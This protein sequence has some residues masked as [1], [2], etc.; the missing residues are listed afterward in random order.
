MYGIPFGPSS[1][2]RNVISMNKYV[3]NA[4]TTK[5]YIE[6][7]V[8]QNASGSVNITGWTLASEASG[9][10]E[11]IPVGTRVP[12][13][14]VVNLTQNILL[15]P[16]DRAIISSGPSPIGLSFRENKCTGYFNDFQKFSPPLPQNCPT[17]SHELSSFYGTRYIHDPVCIDYANTVPRCRVPAEGKTDLS[18]TCENFLTNYLNYNGCVN[19]HSGDAD[20]N[21]TTWRIYLGRRAATGKTKPMWRTDHEI[22]KLFDDRYKTVDSFSY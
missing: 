6:I 22:V 5:E 11:V 13:F 17:A 8:A 3:S 14:G 16:G 15:D 1:Q 21:G 19:A 20:F 18:V 7:S 9:N 2:Y 10:T 12:T 4:D